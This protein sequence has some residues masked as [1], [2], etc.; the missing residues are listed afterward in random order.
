[1][2][3]ISKVKGFLVN[4]RIRLKHFFSCEVLDAEYECIGDCETAGD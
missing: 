3:F 2:D 1:M 4:C